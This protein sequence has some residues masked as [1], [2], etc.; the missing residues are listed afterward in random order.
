[1]LTRG[2][3][4]L[5]M[6]KRVRINNSGCLHFCEQGIVSVIYPQGEWHLNLTSNNIEVLKAAI[7]EKLDS[8]VE[9]AP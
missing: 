7:S 2:L 9:A 6:S 1:V 4:S 5:R 3:K 8:P